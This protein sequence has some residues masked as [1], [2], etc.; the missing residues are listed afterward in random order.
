MVMLVC[1]LG[2]VLASQEAESDEALRE[3]KRPRVALVLGGGGAKGFVHIAVLEL[4]E[5]LGIPV[6]MVIGVSSGAI[7]GGLYSAGYSPEM[8]KEALADL[9]WA[10]LFQDKPVSPFA[11]EAGAGDLPL[12]LRLDGG[13][14]P[15]WGKGY[16]SGEKAY[17]L[18]K[19]LTAK[20]PSYTD[21][22]RLLVPF[23]AA[24]ADVAKGGVKLLK[25]GDLAEA[26]R[27]SISIQGVFEP[28][29]IDGRRYIDGGL[30]N[31]LPVRPAREMGFD[32]VIAVDLFSEPE[33]LDAAPLEA[34]GLMNDLYSYAMSKDQHNL[35]DLVL[36]PDVRRFSSWDYSKARE[37]FTLKPEEKERLRNSLLTVKE[38]IGAFSPVKQEQGAYRDMQ[39]LVIRDL[40]VSGA[41][42]ADRAYIERAFDRHIRGKALER[43]NLSAFA[44]QIYRTGNY[45]F[46]LIRTGPRGREALMELLLYPAEKRKTL[47]L[48]GGTYAGTFSAESISR[49][50]LGSAVRFSGLTGP[51]SALTLGASV[52]DELSL[53]LTYLQPLSARFFFSLSGEILRDQD[54]VIQGPLSHKGR[55]DQ[56]LR[57]SGML[58]G[59]VYINPHHTISAGARFS[60]IRD[61]DI[62]P[63]VSADSGNRA[64]GF[65]VSYRFSSLDSLLFP[66][67]GFGGELENTLFLPLPAGPLKFQDVVTMDI[68][69]AIPLTKRF[70]IIAE[71]FAGSNLSVPHWGFSSP[72]AFTGFSDA[73]RAFFPYMAGTGRY[74]AHKAAASL[75]FRFLPLKNLTVLGGRL[76]FSLSLAAGEVMASSWDEFNPQDLIWCASLGAGLG[77]TG[78]FGLQLRAGAGAS[79]S[80]RP[81]PFIALDI[82]S[83]K[84]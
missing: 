71:G 58:K 35:A 80:S 82:G 42:G 51:G 49:V 73:D 24:A 44:D 81:Q 34:I 46:V 27:A 72:L 4:I 83:F 70:S 60:W 66:A 64:L 21:F 26:I 57:A 32:I 59:G 67:R 13:I 11:Q 61:E 84:Q 6:D 1:F 19:G 18:F 54:A 39:P 38:K 77:L 9:D 69:A 20:L 55:V 3:A 37:I 31:N 50:S 65:T 5:E 29:I 25:E 10:S 47:F 14:G 36:S 33:N 2:G 40:E 75:G 7:V 22:D 8:M 15:D 78:S 43:E 79:A 74:G 56:S 16:S 45:L 28:F 53:G 63:G 62:P 68:T 23:R 48:A 30:R 52:M 17:L 41:L 76:A 12:S